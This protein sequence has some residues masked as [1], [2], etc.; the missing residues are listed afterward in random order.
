MQLSDISQS[1]NMADSSPT[2]DLENEED[3]WKNLIPNIKKYDY[4]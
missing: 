1:A 2:V 4:L 3:E